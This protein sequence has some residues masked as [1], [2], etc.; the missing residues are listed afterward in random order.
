MFDLSQPNTKPGP[1][2]KCRGRGTYHW[3]PSLNGR[4]AKSGPCHSCGGTGRQS[5][6]DMARNTAYNSYKI[7]LICS[8]WGGR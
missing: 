5:R 4:P 6:A 8:E 3:G 7:A 2:E 1:C